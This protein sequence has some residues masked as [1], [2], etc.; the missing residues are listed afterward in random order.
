MSSTNAL[1]KTLERLEEDNET[2]MMIQKRVGRHNIVLDA[3]SVGND[4]LVV[5]YGG[6]EHHIGAVAVAYPTMSH[7]KAKG[8]VSLNSL[9]L[10]GHSDYV[11][12]NSAAEKT[13]KA[14][15][16]TT[17]VTVGIHMEDASKE[18]IEGAVEAADL[19]VDEMIAHHKKPL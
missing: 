14:L 5:I 15:R 18:E 12:A 13:C 2:A 9:T 10:P 16:I 19:M 1:P 6:D 7:Y 8:T 4:L 11:V 3:R 17:V